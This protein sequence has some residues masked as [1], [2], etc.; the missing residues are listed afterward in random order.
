M[1]D[2]DGQ[3]SPG[4]LALALV[5]H[6]DKKDEM[7]DFATAHEEALARFTLFATGTTGARVMERCPGSRSRG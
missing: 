4:R 7:A 6:D 1:A 2:Q 5:A 3:L